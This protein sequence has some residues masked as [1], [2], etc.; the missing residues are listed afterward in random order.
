MSKQ[1]NTLIAKNNNCCHNYLWVNNAE[2]EELERFEKAASDCSP[3]MTFRGKPRQKSCSP[4]THMI[5]FPTSH[6]VLRA[7]YDFIEVFWETEHWARKKGAP[8][9]TDPLKGLTEMMGET[10][11]YYWFD[12]PAKPPMAFLRNVR[13][14]MNSDTHSENNRTPIRDCRT[15]VGA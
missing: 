3:R 1:R 2:G 12:T 10:F 5:L 4:G 8:A 14:P 6:H 15:V 11:P 7:E 9:K 13:I